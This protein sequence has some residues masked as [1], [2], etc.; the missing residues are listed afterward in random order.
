MNDVAWI[1]EKGDQDQND[2]RKNWLM[3]YPDSSVDPIFRMKKEEI[4]KGCFRYT[5]PFEAADLIA[6]EH[7][8]AHSVDRKRKRISWLRPTE[9]AY[10]ADEVS[11][12]F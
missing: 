12:R 4:S 1:F 2:L 8:H 9:K 11:A 6:Y 3:V 7:L 5:R 10:A